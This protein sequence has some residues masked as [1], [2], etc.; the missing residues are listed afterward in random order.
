MLFAMKPRTPPPR[1]TIGDRLQTLRED[2]GLS[3][4]QLGAR[5]GIHYVTIADIERKDRLSPRP[6]T[7]RALAKA[8]GMPAAS[9]LGATRA[10]A[11]RTGE[12]RARSGAGR[13]NGG[14]R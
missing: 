12:N 6:S 2:S 9:L 5:S 8:L 4:R 3:Q 10:Q 14:A 11:H 13:R 1:F 7:L